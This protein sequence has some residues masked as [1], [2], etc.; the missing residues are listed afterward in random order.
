MLSFSGK[1]CIGGSL[2]GKWWLGRLFGM[3]ERHVEQ[4]ERKRR[5]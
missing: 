1:E 4:T 5:R 3:E 2:K